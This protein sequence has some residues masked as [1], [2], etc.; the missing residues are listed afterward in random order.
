MVF[1]GF[2][3]L[4][5]KVKQATPGVISE[6]RSAHIRSVMITGDNVV[7]ACAVAKECNMVQP[8][9]TLLLASA[10]FSEHSLQWELQL[11]PSD[12]ELPGLSLW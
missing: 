9:E 4:Q 8:N 6:L 5:N 10:V 11:M 12:G 7:T 1:L 2:L 3:I